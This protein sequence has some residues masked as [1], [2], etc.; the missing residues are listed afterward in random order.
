MLYK[1]LSLR[2]ITEIKLPVKE[3]LFQ[4]QKYKRDLSVEQITIPKINYK[5][6]IRVATREREGEGQNT[7]D[8][9]TK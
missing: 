6:A 5:H 3:F 1:R 4:I 7:N 2:I 8:P 9:T